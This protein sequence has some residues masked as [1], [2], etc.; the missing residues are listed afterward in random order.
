MSLSSH[1]ALVGPVSQS[2]REDQQAPHLLRSCAAAER[3]AA[4][5]TEALS[6]TLY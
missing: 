3:T 4:M 1:A 6:W 5:L 2:F